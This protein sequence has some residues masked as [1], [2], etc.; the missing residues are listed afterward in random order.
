MATIMDGKALSG[1]FREEMKERVAKLQQE[2]GIIPGLAVVMVGDDPASAI[3]VNNKDK[4]CKELG[5]ESFKINLRAEATMEKLL[6][7]I[8]ELNADSRVHGILVQSPLPKHLDEMEIVRSIHPDKDV[9]GFHVVNAGKLFVGERG[10]V[11][12]TPK[13]IMRM[14]DYYKIPIE[15]KHAVVVGRSNIV[16]KPMAMLLLERNATVTI[17]HSRTSDLGEFTRNADIVVAAVGRRGLITGDMVK[18]GAVVVDVGIN[19]VEGSKKIYGDVDFDSVSP[20]ASFIT[21]VPGGVG[22]LTITMLM[23]N[24]LEAAENA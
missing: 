20:V 4:I 9:D 2:K 8:A 19:R 3:Y 6:R 10:F 23:E 1:L 17:C 15:G 18:P 24:T 16:G 21:P 13:G 22:P 7:V 12:C 14:M 11:S 5:F